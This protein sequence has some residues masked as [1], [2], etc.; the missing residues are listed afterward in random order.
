MPAFCLSFH[1]H[2]P[3]CLKHYSFFDIGE[4]SAYEDQAGTEEH[5]NSAIEKRILPALQIFLKR[6][7]HYQGDFRIALTLSGSFLDFCEH[8][9]P[10]VL[11]LLK[12][13]ADTGCVEFLGS[14][15]H[16][17]LS[18]VGSIQEFK[19]QVVLQANRLAA[20]FGQEPTAFANT[21]LIYSDA[22]AR[23]IESMGYQAILAGNAGLFSENLSPS[24]VYR[25]ASCATVKLLLN[26]PLDPTGVTRV[27]PRGK[28]IGLYC[29]LDSNSET[30]FDDT[31]ILAF[32]DQLPGSI[33]SE[34]KGT[35]LTPSQ[36]AREFKASS[37]LSSPDFHSLHP[38]HD[39]SSWLGNEMQKDAL[40]ALYQ[41][42]GAVKIARDPA[43]LRIWRLL[44]DADYFLSMNT[45]KQ[46]VAAVPS[47]G[48]P[49]DAYINFMNILTDLT[50]R[51]E[52]TTPTPPG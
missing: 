49:Y 12:A 9:Q 15:Y 52:A 44:Q 2:Q 48:S 46:S 28:V 38:P 21:G 30:S 6:I 5:L 7:T 3:C 29:T 41:A 50:E 14:P 35:F 8:P 19:E 51:I 25:P 11:D 23:E 37:I 18:S 26:R 33:L 47:H 4:T 24:H 40:Q 27:Q 20:L 17:S 34:H 31:D 43:L 32:L 10:R 36:V 45:R 13:L 16:H 42:E 22:L 39:L 1:I